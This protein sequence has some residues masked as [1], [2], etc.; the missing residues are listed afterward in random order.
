MCVQGP[1]A[2]APW[3]KAW[4]T[5]AGQVGSKGFEARHFAQYLMC[6][7][8]IYLLCQ[9]IECFQGGNSLLLGN[10]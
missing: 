7:C 6:I 5:G 4:G 2:D 8:G 3:G 9:F 1:G 10:K